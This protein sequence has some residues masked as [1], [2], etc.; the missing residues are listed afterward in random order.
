M[1]HAN[2]AEL[3]R[4]APEQRNP[5]QSLSAF[6]GAKLPD[7]QML[8]W[9]RSM[10]HTGFKRPAS[11]SLDVV[12]HV[13]ARRTLGASVEWCS[14]WLLGTSLPMADQVRLLPILRSLPVLSHEM[15]A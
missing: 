14:G 5:K 8:T 3:T 15:A 2:V 11:Y 4:H 1:I 7:D 10:L 13:V 9:A 12:Q 6:T